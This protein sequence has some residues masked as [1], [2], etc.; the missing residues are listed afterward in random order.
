MDLVRIDSQDAFRH[1]GGAAR[2]PG[3]FRDLDRRR[4]DGL[5]PHQ[6]S[7][8][9]DEHARP[10]AAQAAP[11]DVRRLGD[12]RRLH[13]FPFQDPI[14]DVFPARDGLQERRVHPAA[15]PDQAHVFLIVVIRNPFHEPEAVH[16][17]GEGFLEGGVDFPQDR[18]D[19]IP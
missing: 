15:V 10:A 12:E 1:H 18:E 14:E 13:P 5:L 7:G 8:S 19:L 6:P 2:V 17:G 16:V 4:P 9:A 3:L 11:D